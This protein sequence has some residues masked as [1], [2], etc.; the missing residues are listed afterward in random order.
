M[1]EPQAV[2]QL[3][4][5]LGAMVFAAD[6]ALTVKDMRRC[7][8]DVAGQEDAPVLDK[9][10]EADIQQA[11]QELAEELRASRVGFYL[12][13]VAGGYRF[14]SDPTCG[15][16]LR[17]LLNMGQPKRLS[18]PALET[19]A[20]VAYRQPVTRSEIEGVRGVGVGHIVR[21]L[22]EMQ[23]VKIVGRSPLPGRPFTYGTTQTFLEHFGLSGLDELGHLNPDLTRSAAVEQRARQAD[24]IEESHSVPSRSPADEEDPASA[25]GDEA[26]GDSPDPPPHTGVPFS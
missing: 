20:I 23:L 24:W 16:W 3:K 25:Q 26:E 6:H 15:K 5:A 7:L 17:C 9:R 11:L 18:W 13:E 22:M 21:M 19:L 14:Q 10:K 8:R 4:Q 2:P 12:Q 1:S